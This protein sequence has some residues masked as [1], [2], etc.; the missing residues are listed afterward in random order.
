MHNFLSRQKETNFSCPSSVK[1]QKQKKRISLFTPFLC[2]VLI[3]QKRTFSSPKTV[4]VK[5]DQ[6]ERAKASIT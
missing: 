4:K 5:T 3:G 6:C 1:G 2:A